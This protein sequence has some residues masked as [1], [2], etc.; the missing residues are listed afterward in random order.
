MTKK[1]V[2][3]AARGLIAQGWCKGHYAKDASGQSVTSI[4]DNARS[5]CAAGAL[6]N[7]LN[8]PPGE[9]LTR[10]DGSGMVE[11]LESFLGGRKLADYN[12]HPLTKQEDV[13][14]LFDKAIEAAA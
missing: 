7:V 4:D 9:V 2:L 8:K 13:L 5:F 10:Q 11:Y 12:D 6:S 3:V 14:A 1:E